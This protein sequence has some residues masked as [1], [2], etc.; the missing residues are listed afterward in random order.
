M[1]IGVACNTSHQTA[2]PATANAVSKAI[3][4]GKWVF[5]P[6]QVIPQ[7]GSSRY[8]DGSY[9][10]TFSNNKLVVHLPYFGKAYSGANTFSSNG[11]L[12]FTSSNF[13][14]DQLKDPKG[15]WSIA[16]KPKDY[17]EVQTMNFTFYSNGTANLS[18][19]MNNRSPI[20]FS[21]GVEPLH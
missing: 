6:N 15:K 11:P 9:S 1:I 12:D 13:V 20:S 18:V 2:A 10:V 4:S 14:M 7:Y 21:G 3:D 17:N 8:A 16:L 5:A 19:T